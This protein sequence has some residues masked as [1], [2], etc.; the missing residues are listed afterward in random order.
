MKPTMIAL[1][2]LLLLTAC[3]ERDPNAPIPG[4]YPDHQGYRA[5]PRSTEPQQ[6]APYAPV[7]P[8]TPTQEHYQSPGGTRPYP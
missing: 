2:V 3:E 6:Y 5:N 1:A 8:P 4:A 7:Q